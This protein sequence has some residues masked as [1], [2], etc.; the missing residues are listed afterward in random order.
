M[1]PVPAPALG[2]LSREDRALSVLLATILGRH[3]QDACRYL[4]DDRA[5]GVRAAVL[6]L[7]A[8]PVADRG[9]ALAREAARLATPVRSDLAQLHPERRASIEALA[10]FGPRPHRA[11]LEAAQ[12]LVAAVLAPAPWPDEIAAS[13]QPIQALVRASTARLDAVAKALGPARMR[14]VLECASPAVAA[15]IRQRLS[16]VLDE[17][18]AAVA[19][20]DRG[21]A[22]AALSDL[23]RTEG[24]A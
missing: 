17:A 2:R 8:L 20:A 23:T 24:T 18:L 5:E 12:A 15:W 10:R 6:A 3:G 7:G 1:E 16:P 14:A 9:A 21:P 19:A 11:A 13:P 4:P 22:L